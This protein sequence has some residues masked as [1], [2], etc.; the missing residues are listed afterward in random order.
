MSENYIQLPPV[1]S[2]LAKVGHLNLKPSPPLAYVVG[3]ILGDGNVSKIKKKQ[4]YD[5]RV[6]LETISRTFAESFALA[7]SKL[8]LHP[9]FYVEKRRT[10]KGNQ[11]YCVDSYSKT[12]YEWFTSLGDKGIRE[13]AY[14]YPLDFLRGFYESEGSFIKRLKTY[15]SIK[16]GKKYEYRYYR[17]EVYI[18]NSDL[19]LLSLIAE[20]LG[21]MGIKYYWRKNYDGKGINALVMENKHALRFIEVV[22]PCI[23]RVK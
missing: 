8:G 18:Y 4:G 17:T 14:A 19:N 7:L 23:K 15:R 12:F 13:I 3:V 6:R 2:P 16:K 21:G 22:Q 1:E 20:L 10:A 5:Y 9:I 11:I